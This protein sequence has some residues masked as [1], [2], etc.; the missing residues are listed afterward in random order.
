ML[1]PRFFAIFTLLALTTTL[2]AQETLDIDTYEIFD[3]RDLGLPPA[4][5]IDPAYLE[6]A[7]FE[8]VYCSGRPK[9]AAQLDCG[10]RAMEYLSERLDDPEAKNHVIRTRVENECLDPARM[11]AFHTGQCQS[12]KGLQRMYAANLSEIC[13]C[14][15][16]EMAEGLIERTQSGQFNGNTM[17]SV[18]TR[19]KKTC[20][21]QLN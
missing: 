10:C 21:T 9:M 19:A 2:S 6:E 8:Y 11:Q 20:V 14:I 7:N 16:R 15:G 1:R 17:R 12:N 4:A 5:E 13:A 18:R 3:G